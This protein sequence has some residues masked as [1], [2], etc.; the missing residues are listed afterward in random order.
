[1]QDQDDKRYNAGERR[2]IGQNL[3]DAVNDGDLEWRGSFDFR[4]IGNRR[5]N[6]LRLLEQIEGVT[7]KAGDYTVVVF[8]NRPARAK[9]E[10]SIVELRMALSYYAKPGEGWE[11]TEH[12]DAYERSRLHV[13]DRPEEAE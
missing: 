3:A 8:R 6:G 5:E 12:A 1:M 13:P 4:T 11:H 10:K 2:K 9:L 7:P